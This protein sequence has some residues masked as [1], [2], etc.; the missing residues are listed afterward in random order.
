MLS[1]ESYMDGEIGEHILNWV[2]YSLENNEQNERIL[3]QVSVKEA[4]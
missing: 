2:S 4:T 1:E 3:Y